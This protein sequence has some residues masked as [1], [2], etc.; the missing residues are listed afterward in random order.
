M[1]ERTEEEKA[2][3]IV[4]EVL[5]GNYISTPVI[6]NKILGI[7]QAIM[8]RQI[9][10][11]SKHE[12]DGHLWVYNSLQSWSEVTGFKPHQVRYALDK[13][14]DNNLI[15][16]SDIYNKHPQDRTM[17]YRVNPGVLGVLIKNY[18]NQIP[19]PI[20]PSSHEKAE[21][22]RASDEFRIGAGNEEVY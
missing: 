4:E 20:K 22:N 10:V 21:M 13:L 3:A 7:V 18:N 19:E 11:F 14:A 5:T 6:L 9:A 15:I 8:F 1:K 16:R 2:Y 12:R 17:W